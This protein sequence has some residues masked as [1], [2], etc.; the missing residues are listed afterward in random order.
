MIWRTK[1]DD[2]FRLLAATHQQL[3]WIFPDSRRYRVVQKGNGK[4]YGM[5]PRGS[6]YESENRV[7][8]V[9]R[10]DQEADDFL[11]DID[12]KTGKTLARYQLDS[13]ETH[14]ALAEGDRFFVTDT[15]R[16]RV[17]E[18]ELANLKLVNVFDQFTHDNHVNTVYLEDG[19]MWVLCH[20]KG[21][22]SLVELDRDS[23]AILRTIKGVGCRSHDIA[24]WNDYLVIC[25]S[26]GGGLV[27]VDTTKNTVKSVF[28]GDGLFTKGLVVQDDLA[29]FA[30][31]PAAVRE[32]RELVKC[33]LVAFN[34][35]SQREV[36]RWS[37]P[38]GGLVNSIVSHEGLLRQAG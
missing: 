27:L 35:S 6:K 4:Y 2:K 10:P 19:V 5:S 30:I 16:G 22:S 18:Y 25:D 21:E 31:S 33:D 29:W 7:L 17:L 36:W 11:L 34:L 14:F 8:V 9:S 3:I 23:G 13:R 12:L 15:Y 37:I 32:E 38:S 20:N 24:R 26:R 28:K 1:A